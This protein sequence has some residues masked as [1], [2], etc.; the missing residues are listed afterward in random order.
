MLSSGFKTTLVVVAFPLLASCGGGGSSAPA[1]PPS[2]VSV[3]GVAALGAP[4]VNAPVDAVCQG[5][6]G[7]GTT[8]AMGQF[9]FN[10]TGSAPCV[11]QVTLPSG[12]LFQ[13]LLMPGNSQANLTPLTTLMVDFLKARAGVLNATTSTELANSELFLDVLNNPDFQLKNSKQ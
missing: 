7:S 6:R 1:A 12:L 5:G 3:R 4:L 10:V 8:N 9:D 2:S 13:S 11:L